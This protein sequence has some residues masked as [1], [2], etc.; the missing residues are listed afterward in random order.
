M[1]LPTLTGWHAQYDLMKRTYARLSQPYES[2]I[3]YSDDLQHFFQDCWHLK[4]WIKNDDS[5][6]LKDV[7]ED[8]VHGP[9]ALRIVSDLAIGSK[10]L[11]RTIK[12]LEGAYVTSQNVTAHL[13]Q[14]RGVIVSHTV[15][16][17]DGSTL[18]AQDVAKD[19][20]EAWESVL[21]KLGLSP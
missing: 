15:A 13:A 17:K 21:Q 4:D 6:N 14:D 8:E 3:D 2:S 16:L 20:M 12:N 18:S 19:A 1:L 9:K 11:V 5:L 7:I 10:H